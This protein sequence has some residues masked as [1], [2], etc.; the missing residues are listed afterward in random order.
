MSL[1]VNAFAVPNPASD[2]N[3]LGGWVLNDKFSD[4]FDGT[5]LDNK[6]FV[7]GTNDP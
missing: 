7:Q 3:N 4:E 6:W 1:V 5:Q 2:S